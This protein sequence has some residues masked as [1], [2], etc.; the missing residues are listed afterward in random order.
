MQGFWSLPT[1]LLSPLAPEACRGEPEE[2]VI[3]VGVNAF[4]EDVD[5]FLAVAG[6]YPFGVVV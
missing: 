5:E 4:E 2:M 6:E 1:S 3:I